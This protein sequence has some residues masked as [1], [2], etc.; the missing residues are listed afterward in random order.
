M[1][2]ANIGR[3]GIAYGVVSLNSL[4]EWVFD[5]FLMGGENTSESAEIEEWEHDNL[6]ASESERDEF[7][8]SL[9]IDEA[10]YSL[11]IDGMKLALG[12]LGGAA[13]IWVFDSPHTTMAPVC[14]PC[15]PNAGDLDNKSSGAVSSGGST[16]CFNLPADWYAPEN[17]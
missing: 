16:L 13:L 4:Q 17:F 6:H 5:E 15:V 3:D 1:A 9:E 10:T 14:S 2:I 8:D 11:E 12:W 7:I